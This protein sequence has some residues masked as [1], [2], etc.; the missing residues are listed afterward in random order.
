MR[1][2]KLF[3]LRV[4]IALVRQRASWSGTNRFREWETRVT[5]LEYRAA[6]LASDYHIPRAGD[7]RKA[8]FF[9][10][11]FEALGVPTPSTGRS[12][13]T[14]H[15]PPGQL[16]LTMAELFA[17]RRAFER[18]YT[19]V[20]ATLQFE[21]FE[22]LREGKRAKAEIA[23]LRGYVSFG[24]AVLCSVLQV[25]LFLRGFAALK[26]IILPPPKSGD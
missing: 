20:V 26:G 21:Y 24:S 15:E 23:R 8:G 4:W 14:I 13:I 7:A 16:L 9:E 19:E 5:D 3:L 6:Q 18:V 22:A 2:L 25:P 12:R 10:K 11:F 1:L 17:S